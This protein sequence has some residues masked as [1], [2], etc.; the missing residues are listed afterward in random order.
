MRV[1]WCIVQ[2][3]GRKRHCQA[4][5]ICGAS[6]VGRSRHMEGLGVPPTL[7]SMHAAAIGAGATMHWTM[8]DSAPLIYLKFFADV[9]LFS[10]EA[11]ST[12][13]MPSL[14][15]LLVCNLFCFVSYSLQN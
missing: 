5:R 7:T 10:A 1:A 15:V 3:R 8:C 11:M 9:P 6:G 14:P 12:L 4:Y 13:G 2:A